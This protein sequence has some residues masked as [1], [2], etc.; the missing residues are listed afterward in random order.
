[1]LDVTW[2]ARMGYH[3]PGLSGSLLPGSYLEAESIPIFSK[4]A[5][6]VSADAL[7]DYVSQL[8][9]E[10]RKYLTKDVNYGKVAKRMYNVFRLTA[11]TRSG[12][13]EDCSTSRQPCLPG[14]VPDPHHR[15]R[16]QPVPPSRSNTCCPRPT[17]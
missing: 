1:M 3:S 12:F 10:V 4:L 5:R 11:V 8:E 17:T 16:S 13:P 14:L 6:H 2:E 7:E 9:N 15:R